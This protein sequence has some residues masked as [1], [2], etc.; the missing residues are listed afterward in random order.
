[1]AEQDA[2]LIPIWDVTRSKNL[3]WLRHLPLLV[4]CAVSINQDISPDSNGVAFDLFTPAGF[5]AYF[6]THPQ[7]LPPM[8]PAAGN[9]AQLAMWRV[10]NEDFRAQAKGR[11]TLRNIVVASVPKELLVPMQDQNRSIRLRTTEYIVS[12]L[13]AQLGTLTQEDLA[14][15]MRQ[16]KEPYQV[17]TSV[18]SFLADWNASLLD[19]QRAGQ[20]LPQVMATDTLMGCFGSEFGTCWLTFVKDV[21]IIANRTVALLCAAITVFAVD[22]L[23]LITAQ[24]AIGINQVTSQTAVLM[25][26]QEQIDTLTQALAVEQAYT[27]DRKRGVPPPPAF[28][29][30]RKAPNRTLPMSARLFC[31]THGPCGTH[32]GEVCHNQ[33]P[34][35]KELATWNNQMGS[36]WKAA[37]NHKGWP[38]T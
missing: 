18:P 23:P 1:M 29:A 16:L 5:F 38:I 31:W 9:A 25:K 19:L 13:S 20:P 27:A 36:K 37:Y 24:S 30:K 8:G 26:M 6:G 22:A 7:P 14:F 4:D 2:Q 34:G 35:H 28:A 12:T 17:G 33:L 3:A 21:P 10:G 11:V 15:L 32:T